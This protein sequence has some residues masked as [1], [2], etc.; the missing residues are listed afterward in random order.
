MGSFCSRNVKYRKQK[1]DFKNN[2]LPLPEQR[3]DKYQ[4][5]CVSK[6]LHVHQKIVSDDQM[7]AHQS[8]KQMNVEE[9]RETELIEPDTV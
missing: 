5:R 9:T 6:L 7:T 2:Q 3:F 1:Q 4:V 8:L